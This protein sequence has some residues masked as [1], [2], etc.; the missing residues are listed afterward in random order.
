MYSMSM[1]YFSWI[2]SILKV[3]FKSGTMLVGN[4]WL[5]N[6]IVVLFAAAVSSKHISGVGKCYIVGVK[7]FS[8]CIKERVKDN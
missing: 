1:K 3:T 5:F 4:V 2:R 6:V 8:A 7:Y